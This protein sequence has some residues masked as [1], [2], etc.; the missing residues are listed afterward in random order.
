MEGGLGVNR[1]TVQEAGERGKK[2]SRA[3][4]A[5]AVPRVEERDRQML[6][7]FQNANTLG[8]ISEGA[9]GRCWVCF[10]ITSLSL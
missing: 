5:A 3:S 8:D 9:G 10:S 2:G 1:R 7:S 4:A 6:R